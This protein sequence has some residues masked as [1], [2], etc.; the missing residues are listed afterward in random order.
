[1]A[2]E[3]ELRVAL[4]AAAAAGETA[5][6]FAREGFST[7]FKPDDSPVTAADKACEEM[8]AG[9]LSAEFPEDGLLGEEGA[10]SPGSSGRR[11]IIDPIDGTRDFVRGNRFWANFLALED[12]SGPALGIVSFPALGELYW[13][14]RGM[15]SWRILEGREARIHA[16]RVEDLSKAVGCVNGLSNAD[17][18][19]F[20]ASLLPF[21]GR[22]SAIRS[23][24]GALDAMHV[25]S[26]L[27]DFWFEASA[28]PWDL[29]PLAVIARE[30]GAR[31]H[32]HAGED[33][34]YGGNA[35]IFAPGLETAV[36]EFLGL[37]QAS[38]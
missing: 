2:F 17:S 23:M 24:G 10:A 16:S 6:R 30:S 34:I 36:R 19:P 28:K 7:E 22:F 25:C 27:A 14:A 38:E 5:L 11:W 1:M 33:T 31:F 21:L 8:L 13:A 37:S 15:G 9:M 29:A 35:V 32:S 18:S 26:G 3:R 20:A 12:A 4:A